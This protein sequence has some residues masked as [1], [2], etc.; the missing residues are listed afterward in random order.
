MRAEIEVSLGGYM[1][2]DTIAS[3]REGVKNPC[4][5]HFSAQ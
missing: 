5:A 4:P 3:N 2:G 1:A